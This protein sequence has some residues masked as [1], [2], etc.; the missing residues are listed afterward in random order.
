MG[1]FT[2]KIDWS[3]AAIAPDSRWAKH[4]HPA[5]VFREVME[6]V[7]ASAD[8][9]PDSVDQVRI[10]TGI[11]NVFSGQAQA[12]LSGVNQKGAAA[13]LDDI[14]DRPDFDESMPWTYLTHFEGTGVAAH[15]LLVE[16]FSPGGGIDDTF[17]PLIRDGEFDLV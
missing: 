15:N 6:R 7:I 17:V 2:P 13:G 16:L 4:T 14:F 5:P 8:R 1:F 12:Y 9:S 10:L 11:Y 3:T